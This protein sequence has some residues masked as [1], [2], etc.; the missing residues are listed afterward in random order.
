LAIDLINGSTLPRDCVDDPEAVPG[1][2]RNVKLI[3]TTSGL[4]LWAE[5]FDGSLDDVFTIQDH[6]TRR[7]VEALAVTLTEKERATLA[8]DRTTNVEALQ[9]YFIGRA[10]YGSASKQENEASRKMFRRAIDLDPGYGQAYA[11]LAL[12]YLDDWQ[13]D[14]SENPEQSIAKAVSLAQQAISVDETL[15]EAH[16]TLG[17]IHLY[18]NRQHERAI[19]EAEKA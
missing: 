9:H 15:P 17:Y 12:T 3:D 7:V 1:N 6:V 19:A 13:R 18:A 11:A 5:R 10:D 16:F 4:N 14:W 2:A 8:R